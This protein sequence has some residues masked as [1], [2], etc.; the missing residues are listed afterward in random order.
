MKKL[1]QYLAMWII[2]PLCWILSCLP[3]RV[4]YIFSDMLY[5]LAYRILKYRTKVVR[6][7]LLIAFPEKTE[8]ERKK[9]EETFY[10]QLTDYFLE[11][12]GVWG[13]S[14]KE[15]D[16]RVTYSNTELLQKFYNNGQ[17]VILTAGH[18]GN[19]EISANLSHF[20]KFKLFAVYKPLSNKYMNNF[21]LRIRNRSGIIPT[22]MNDTLRVVASELRKKERFGIYLLGDQ[23]PQKQYCNLWLNFM[24][25]ETPVLNGIEKISQKYN[26]PVVFLHFQKKSRGYYHIDIK[27]VTENPQQEPEHAIMKRYFQMLEENIRENEGLYLWSHNRWKFSSLEVAKEHSVQFI[28]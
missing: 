19:W 20:T 8:A 28:D 12:V 2:Y 14:D 1:A 26:I 6:K 10:H 23:R 15:I 21:L 18:I 11:S 9:I 3:M 27:L 5:V 17:N 16:K 25:K 7:N 22:P 4:L 13:I 24:N